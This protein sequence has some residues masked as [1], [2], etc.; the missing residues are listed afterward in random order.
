MLVIL[1][2]NS[3]QVGM[4]VV[5]QPHLVM[6]QMRNSFQ[7]KDS[8]LEF[9]WPVMHNIPF[10]FIK[11]LHSEEEANGIYYPII[12]QQLITLELFLIAPCIVCSKFDSNQMKNETSDK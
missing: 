6:Q 11:Y 4:A 8:G 12:L 9:P 5:I 2:L 10:V 3:A 1:K 7:S